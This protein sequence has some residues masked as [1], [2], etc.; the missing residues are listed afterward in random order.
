[1]VRGLLRRVQ[2]GQPPAPHT[3][4]AHLLGVKDPHTGQL[5]LIPAC[6]CVQRLV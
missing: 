2:A 1:M 6:F 3:L 4:A 5:G